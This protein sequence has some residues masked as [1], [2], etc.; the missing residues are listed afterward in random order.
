MI[1]RIAAAVARAIFRNRRAIAQAIRN[2]EYDL[3]ARRAR[4]T[5]ET[6]IDVQIAKERLRAR[7]KKWGS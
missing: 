4:E 6:E 1:A 7:R 3:A 2:E 5:A